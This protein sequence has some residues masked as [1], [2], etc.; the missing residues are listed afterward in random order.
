M[1]PFQA[2][3]GFPPPQVAEVVISDCPDLTPQEQARNRQV[4]SQV[5]KDTLIK[6]QARIKQHADKNRTDKEFSVGDMVYLKLQPYRYTSLSTHR[7][8]KLHS[9]FYGPFRILNRIGKAA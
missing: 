2:L 6:A 4:A 8:L 1:T 9:K 5:I 3:Y 7:C